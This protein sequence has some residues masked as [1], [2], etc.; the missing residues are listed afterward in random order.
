[1]L[2]SYLCSYSLLSYYQELNSALHYA[3]LFGQT[4]T[5]QFLLQSNADPNIYNKVSVYCI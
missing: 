3:S 4:E 5:V 1:M 2:L